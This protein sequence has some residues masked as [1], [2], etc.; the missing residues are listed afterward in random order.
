M[1]VCSSHFE[2]CYPF[3]SFS[4]GFPIL[5]RSRSIPP[6]LL[7]AFDGVLGYSHLCNLSLLYPSTIVWQLPH[8]ER[9]SPVLFPASSLTW[10]FVSSFHSRQT[11]QFPQ[12]MV[13]SRLAT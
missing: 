3:V 10:S 2:K 1:R 5:T 13:R 4:L 12:A 7:R 11:G 8:M 9:I 6:E